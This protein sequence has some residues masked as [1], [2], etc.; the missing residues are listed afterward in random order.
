MRPSAAILSVGNE[1]LRGSVVN[2][3]AAF[4][5]RELS[6]LGFE[7]VS[8]GVCADSQEAIRFRL[9]DVLRR[10][11]LIV[12]MGGLGPTPDDVTREGIAAHFNV[13]LV[14][15]AEQYRRL[16]K[17][18]KRFGKRISALVKREAFY[19]ANAKP[20]INRFGIAL[21]FSIEA[22]QK[23]VIALP[24]VPSE[25][26][27]M[28]A[29]VV[30]P[31]LRKK[32]AGLCAMRKLVVRMAGISEDDVMKKLGK[33]FF[34]DAFDFGIYPSAGEAGIRILSDRVPVIQRLKAKIADRLK[35]WIYAWDE[36][37]L[38]AVIGKILTRKRKTL[39]VA[40]SCTGGLLAS[41]IT[42]VPGA[43]AFFRGAAVAYH[44]LVKQQ[45]GV[46][47]E[48]IRKYGEVSSQVAAELAKGVRNR[49]ESDY[50]LGITG[51]A[52]PGGGSSKKPVGLVYIG[53]ASPD[54][55]V[56]T[57]KH[58]FWGERPQVQDKAAVKALEYLWRKVR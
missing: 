25:L 41:R 50:G 56:R 43:S 7:V 9:G 54:G 40:E 32:Y 3:N 22:G 4:L 47:G 5:G 37:P 38:P 14:F 36:T 31:V 1:V 15:S 13:P 6:G 24:G 27:H 46:P 35:D 30:L 42:A 20:L 10:A 52:G 34:E 55:K 16:G 39:A 58:I 18:Y 28:Y 26:S 19:P 17:I 51:I 21:G 45:L 2:T 8:H 48:M 11:D 12:V 23:L 44:S 49:M 29:D 57:W 53:L 33:D